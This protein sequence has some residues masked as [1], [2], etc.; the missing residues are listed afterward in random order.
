MVRPRHYEPGTIESPPGLKGRLAAL[1]EAER[2]RKDPL[3]TKE[4]ASK[5]GL[6]V[7]LGEDGLIAKAAE[8]D[9]SALQR[10]IYHEL[11][12]PYH[13]HYALGLLELYHAYM[14]PYSFRSNSIYL[15]QVFGATVSTDY[16]AE[17]YERVYKQLGAL[18]F[19]CISKVCAMD[20]SLIKGNAVL[21]K[22]VQDTIEYLVHTMDGIR[23]QMEEEK[24]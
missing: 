20:Y 19:N 3:I 11:L 13:A 1:L 7:K 14:A 22:Y 10:M 17:M 4:R 12:H 23:K 9:N 18:R 16:A 5:P 24:R 15:A 21:V 6:T 2:E 8:D